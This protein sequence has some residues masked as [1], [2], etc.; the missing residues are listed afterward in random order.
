[1]FTKSAGFFDK[2]KDKS[3]FSVWILD[4]HL[5]KKM[6]YHRILL[7]MTSPLGQMAPKF[8]NYLADIQAKNPQILYVHL[9]PSITKWPHSIDKKCQLGAW[10]REN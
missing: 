3:F 10:T 8:S 4:H 6:S 5:L 1:M 2:E 7:V 9:L